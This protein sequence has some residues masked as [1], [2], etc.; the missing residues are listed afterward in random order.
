MY[1]LWGGEVNALVADVVLFFELRDGSGRTIDAEIP[2]W[3]TFVGM[4]TFEVESQH[5][6]V[7]C[8]NS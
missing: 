6:R 8:I 1:I 2:I 3:M 4:R 5:S 7:W